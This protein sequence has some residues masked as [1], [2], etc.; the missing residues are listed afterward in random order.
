MAD[1]LADQTAADA[2]YRRTVLPVVVDY[3]EHVV[4]G[5]DLDKLKRAAEQVGASELPLINA[6][7]AVRG[8]LSTAPATMGGPALTVPTFSSTAEG[9]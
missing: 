8:A 1:P 9:S 6:L 3:V 4:H 7:I 2:E 5:A